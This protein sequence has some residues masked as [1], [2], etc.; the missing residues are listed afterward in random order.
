MQVPA[1]N[2]V[3]TE[4]TTVEETNKVSPDSTHKLDDRDFLTDPEVAD[5]LT[6]LVNLGNTCFMNSV[7]QCMSHTTRLRNYFLCKCVTF[8]APNVSHLQCLLGILES[9]CFSPSPFP[10]IMGLFFP[11]FSG[12]H[13]MIR[14]R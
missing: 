9:G 14:I 7:V 4:S 11:F 12:K 13:P 10:A 1:A 8:T 6:G 2:K 5:G 3:G